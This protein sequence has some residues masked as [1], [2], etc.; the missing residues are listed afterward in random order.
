MSGSFNPINMVSQIALGV[1]TGGAS[2]VAQFAMQVAMQMGQQ[3]IQNLGQQLGL[4]QDMIDLAKDAMLGAATGGL[5]GAA[6]GAIAGGA[7]GLDSQIEQLGQQTGASPTDIGDAQRK[8]SEDLMRIQNDLAQSDEVK[9]AKS[10]N[11]GGGWLRAMAEVLG[12]KLDDLAHEMQDLAGKV[13]KEDPSTST[14]FTVV[15]QEFN[16]LMNAVTNA[17]KTIGEAMGKSAARQ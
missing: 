8:A 1:A 11:R 14:D 9:E 5:A 10:G 15:S 12:Q 17:L 4:P 2:L 13:N 7:G 6:A 3:L 16:M